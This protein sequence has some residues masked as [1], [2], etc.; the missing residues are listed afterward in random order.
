VEK[1][2]P[3]GARL[4]RPAL[5]WIGTA[6]SSHATWT[7]QSSPAGPWV[8]KLAWLPLKRGLPHSTDELPALALG[9]SSTVDYSARH[10]FWSRLQAA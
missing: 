10:R 8:W 2:T 4:R 7:K 1:S 5:P 3:H 9:T 6:R